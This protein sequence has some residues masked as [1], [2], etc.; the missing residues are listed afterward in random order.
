MTHERRDAV[1][2]TAAFALVFSSFIAL[3]LVLA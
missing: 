3:V 1:M 2:M